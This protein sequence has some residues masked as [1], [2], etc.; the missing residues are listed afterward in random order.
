MKFNPFII[1]W[2]DRGVS[3]ML[4]HCDRRGGRGP[5]RLEIVIHNK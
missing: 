1:P 5:E 3:Q 2:R 4:T